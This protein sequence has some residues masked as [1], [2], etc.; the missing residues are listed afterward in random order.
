MNPD[1]NVRDEP[2]VIE[3]FV[4]LL[5]D[6]RAEDFASGSKIPTSSSVWRVSSSL[7]PWTSTS[8]GPRR[9][10]ARRSPDPGRAGPGRPLGRG[11]STWAADMSVLTPATSLTMRLERAHVQFLGPT[12]CT[13]SSN[14]FTN[15]PVRFR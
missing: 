14:P 15:T 2:V 3:H 4:F 13:H 10:G 11:P 12:P 8:G 1:N 9:L 5:H 6:V 7:R